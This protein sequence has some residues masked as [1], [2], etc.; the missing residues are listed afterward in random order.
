MKRRDLNMFVMT[1]SERLQNDINFKLSIDDWEEEIFLMK[2][3]R[4][5]FVLKNMFQKC[6]NKNNLE[7]NEIQLLLNCD[8]HHVDFKRQNRLKS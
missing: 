3:Q 5:I 8:A 4:E 6:Y 2:Y 7:S 1:E